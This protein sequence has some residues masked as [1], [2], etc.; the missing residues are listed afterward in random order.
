MR[1]S[2]KGAAE[3]GASKISG[4]G[5]PLAR[6][7]ITGAMPR[8]DAHTV[9]PGRHARTF[10]TAVPNVP[11]RL[12]R[13]ERRSVNLVVGLMTFFVLAAGI[14]VGTILGLLY[15]NG[16]SV[17]LRPATG[18]TFELAVSKDDFN[19]GDPWSIL[20]EPYLAN[21]D[22][23]GTMRVRVDGARWYDLP[24]DAGF[25][26]GEYTTY[27][28]EGETFVVVD[29]TLENV[30]AVTTRAFD[31]DS[32]WFSISSFALA[33]AADPKFVR[34]PDRFDGMPANARVD[35]HERLAFSLP[36]G[37]KRSFRLGYVVGK[38]L[39]DKPMVLSVGRKRTTVGLLDLGRGSCVVDMGVI[40]HA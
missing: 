14:V 40:E 23:V 27:G 7:R 34:F 4:L 19:R 11:G 5:P 15:L 33:D 12:T 25:D 10:S 38:D 13:R 9:T 18:E 24:S 22:W 21:L 37:E 2:K 39:I 32:S 36:M 20:T 31:T 8:Y 1:D 6:R 17:S 29:V 30:D 35:L 26:D 28:F 16:K 3:P